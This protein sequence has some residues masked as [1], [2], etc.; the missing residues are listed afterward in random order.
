MSQGWVKSYRKIKNWK[1]YKVEGYALLWNHLLLEAHHGDTPIYDK[2]ANKIEKGMFSTGSYRLSEETGICRSKVCRILK[3]L[4]NEHQ[5][6]IKSSNR[7][8]VITI[9]CWSDYQDNIKSV[10]IQRTSSE[11]PVNIQRT[12]NKNGKNKKNEKKIITT[13]MSESR[14]DAIETFYAKEIS[15][16]QKGALT[17]IN[18]GIDL[19]ID[20]TGY[21][22]L[23]L[24]E[25][26]LGYDIYWVN[27]EA[28][29]ETS[30]YPRSKNLLT[31]LK[32]DDLFKYLCEDSDA[33][34][35]SKITEKE[36]FKS[37]GA[38][39]KELAKNKLKGV[40]AD[41]YL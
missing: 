40:S 9:V 10:N 8:S 7:C 23:D 30:K 20:N 34:G 24:Y 29:G 2:F 19:W 21:T 37:E 4:E 38:K 31:F 14:K 27:L 3:I 26:T 41:T 36:V 11:H 12:Q 33:A 39:F 5:I 25:I 1:F 28:S 22:D 15:K 35:S 13:D 18:K 16:F 17:Q 32:K 6:T